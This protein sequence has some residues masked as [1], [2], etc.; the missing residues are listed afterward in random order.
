MPHDIIISSRNRTLPGNAKA[1]FTAPRIGAP[2]LWRGLRIGLLG[3]SF[4]PAHDGHRH[5]SLMALNALDLDQ[6]W[7]LVSPQNPLKKRDG[8]ASMATRI[9]QAKR[10]ARHPR[11][12]VT[13]LEQQLGTQFTADTL[14]ALSST[15]FGTDFVWLMGADNLSQIRHWD[16]WQVIFN[17]MPVA[18]LARSP[19]SL[20]ACSSLAATRYQR[21]RL[22]RRQSRRLSKAGPPAWVFL[23]IPLHGASASAIRAAG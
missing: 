2:A 20:R 1:A 16:R 8:M 4:N 17:T 3:G 15:F 10:I 13:D 22:A 19:Y 12:R 21:H 14:P 23:P 5:I 7:W 18:V 9:E 6:V 11:I